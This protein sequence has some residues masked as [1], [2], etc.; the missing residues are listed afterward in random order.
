MSR[1]IQQWQHP[2]PELREQARQSSLRA[3]LVELSRRLVR[4]QPQYK[5][6]VK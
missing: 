6:V 4:F 5:L 3:A 2:T 1:R